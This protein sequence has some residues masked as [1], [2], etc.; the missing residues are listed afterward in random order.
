MISRHKEPGP[1]TSRR[2]FLRAVAGIS[3]SSFV[4]AMGQ[5]GPQ[6]EPRPQTLALTPGRHRSRVVSIRQPGL[7]VQGSVHPELVREAL[8]AA[9]TRTLDVPTAA[10]AWHRILEPQDIVGIKFNRSGQP[11]LGT[12]LELGAA[13]V[14]SLLSAGWSRS[15]IVL[16]EAPAGLEKRYGTQPAR[17]GY[18]STLTEFDSG[19]D[20]L[21]SVLD[22]VTV[23]VNVPFLKS[24]NLCMMTCCLKNLSH[25]LVKHPAR[26]HGDGCSPFIADIVALPDIKDKLRLNIVDAIR[27]VHDGGPLVSQDKVSLSETLIV[28]ADP[29]AADAIGLQV[30]NS[31]RQRF[32][33]APAAAST[34]SVTYLAEAHRRD[35]GTALLHGIDFQSIS[36]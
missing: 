22:Q 16:I 11:E 20:Q 30:L 36:R 21:A 6:T 18:R 32:G 13:V 34:Q 5:N 25:A 24:H 19:S 9:L 3:G 17:E 12:S 28:S 4:A 31:E 2:R 14:E 8:A 33:M 15:G 10:D 1:R 35:L 29:V 23:L 27:V 26:F 7:W